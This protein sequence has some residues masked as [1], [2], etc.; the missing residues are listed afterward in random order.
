M[1]FPT[2]M[3]VQHTHICKPILMDLPN[4]VP[5]SNRHPLPVYMNA[6][7]AISITTLSGTKTQYSACPPI[8]YAK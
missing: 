7:K 5:S 1:I 4:P 3:V 6:S 2:F 8:H